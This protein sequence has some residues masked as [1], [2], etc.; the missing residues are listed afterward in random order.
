MKLITKQLLK[1]FMKSH[2][3][4][5]I[6]N[7]VLLSSFCFS[8]SP[9]QKLKAY[10]Y[11]TQ[12]DKTRIARFEA[13]LPTIFDDTQYNATQAGPWIKE[14]IKRDRQ[15]IA[16]EYNNQR[17]YLH[18]Q[19]GRRSICKFSDRNVTPF[20]ISCK[21]DLSVRVWDFLNY[22]SKI[23]TG[24]ASIIT[25]LDISNNDKY[26]ITGSVDGKIIFWDL[27]NYHATICTGDQNP[28]TSLRFTHQSDYFEFESRT[29]NSSYIWLAI[30]DEQNKLKVVTHDTKKQSVLFFNCRENI[31]HAVS[32]KFLQSN[33]LGCT[34]LPH[35]LQDLIVGYLGSWEKQKS[36][37]AH[38]GPTRIYAHND[39]TFFTESVDQRSL[40]FDPSRAQ[41]KE[42]NK[43]Q[44]AAIRNISVNKLRMI[45]RTRYSEDGNYQALYDPA[46][47]AI[48][49]LDAH[50]KQTKQ[51]IDLGLMLDI[52]DML[53]SSD[54]A[55]LFLNNESIDRQ[56]IV[57]DTANGKI[58]QVLKVEHLFTAPQA[59]H[60]FA[61]SPNGLYLAVSSFPGA[62]EIWQKEGAVLQELLNKEREE[63]EK[64][65]NQI[66]T[67]KKN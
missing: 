8:M 39:N 7:Y 55:Y 63:D 26:I 19:F 31:E 50:T 37:Q 15:V 45:G 65:Q 27:E 59:E 11:A 24:H 32:H 60:S 38:A 51:I 61:L 17:I 41:I 14:H 48:T 29:Q 56:I 40:I 22:K 4:I 46:T 43:A 58:T 12:Q 10:L 9:K 16:D 62:I 2:W 6:F 3:Y 57:I 47:G 23:L 44:I 35:E 42:I 36:Y 52:T 25:H 49:I 54:N 53:F 20:Y 30:P 64:L 66:M 33:P 34:T 28:I 67:K 21:E 13:G 5:L 1:D 18:G